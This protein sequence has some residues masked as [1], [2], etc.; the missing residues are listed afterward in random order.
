MRKK[1]VELEQGVIIAAR[2]FL[3]AVLGTEQGFSRPYG[4]VKYRQ[5]EAAVRALDLLD[6][7]DVDG[8]GARWNAGSETSRDAAMLAAP[9]QASARHAIIAALAHV[10]PMVEPGYTD[11]QL[12]RRLGRSHQ[13]VSS[14]RNWLVNHGWVC[15]SGVKR[16][17]RSNRDAV[18][19]SLTPDASR[20]LREVPT[21]A[22]S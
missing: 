19:W 5:L 6:A 2:G 7:A 21:W 16:K 8:S 1:R 18:V 13:T 17:T 14:A 20:Q 10:P 22:K 4:Q 11:E 9:V 12:E 3:A 15:D